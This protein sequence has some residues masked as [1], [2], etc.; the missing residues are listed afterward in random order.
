MF[1]IRYDERL[2]SNDRYTYDCIK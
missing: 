2:I 1:S